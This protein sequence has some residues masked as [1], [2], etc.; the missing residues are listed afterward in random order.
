MTRSATKIMPSTAPSSALDALR[1][2]IAD[3]T[4]AT[5]IS[6]PETDERTGTTHL[7]VSEPA[8]ILARLPRIHRARR[9][10]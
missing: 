6:H 5:P 2:F 1:R 3:R 10:L 4:T 8:P 7:V 9:T